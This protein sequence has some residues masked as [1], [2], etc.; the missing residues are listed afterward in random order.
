MKSTLLVVVMAGLTM[1]WTWHRGEAAEPG[2]APAAVTVQ[3]GVATSPAAGPKPVIKAD[4]LEHNFG[5]T[6]MGE[7]LKHSF[8][9]T[10]AGDADL[11]ITRVQPT[12]GCTIAGQ[13]PSTLKPGES[14]DFPFS[15]NTQTLDGTY[16]K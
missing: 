11:K 3:P 8:K 1:G 9:V 4:A 2:A 7:P 15:L 10:N 6:W 5:T 16:G 12:C 14:G 13:Y